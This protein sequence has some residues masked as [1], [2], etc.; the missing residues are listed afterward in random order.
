MENKTNW[1]AIV[2]LV[3]SIISILCC[4]VWYIALIVAVAAVIFGIWG[5]CNGKPGLRDAAAAGIVVGSVG[6]A[7]AVATAIFTI[8]FY[9]NAQASGVELSMLTEFGRML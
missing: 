1:Q 5:L 8:M 3:L 4:C 6:A 7:L 9:A 2:S